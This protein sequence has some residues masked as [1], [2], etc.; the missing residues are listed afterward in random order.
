[1]HI[2]HLIKEHKK[3]KTFFFLSILYFIILFSISSTSN[4]SSSTTA[5]ISDFGAYGDGIHDD[6]LAIQT[7]LNS[8]YD[9]IIFKSGEYKITDYITLTT[10]N[11]HIIGNQSIIF[12]D[13]DYRSRENYYEWVINIKANNIYIEGITFQARETTLVGYKTQIGIQDAENI[14][15]NSCCLY[16]PSTVYQ[17]SSNRDIEYSNLDLYSNWKDVHISSC[18]LLNYADTEHGVCIEFRDIKNTGSKNGY[19]TDSVCISNCHDEIIAAFSSSSNNSKKINNIVI[20]NNYITALNTIH[21]SPRDVGISLGYNPNG[22]SNLTFVNNHVSIYSD[23]TLFTIGESNNIY[24]KN[25]QIKYY[26][27]ANSSGY[28]AR[29]YAATDEVFFQNNKIELILGEKS[30]IAKN[31]YGNIKYSSNTITSN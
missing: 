30:K 28:I 27:L 12:T 10:N 15:L 21:S 2:I 22:V 23:F 24:I 17:K 8:E 4:A 11:K 31:Y 16:I 5:Y 19:L 6:T 14:T 26:I 9:T 29:S 18:L 25:N 20:R 1:M 3:K 13:N 7:A